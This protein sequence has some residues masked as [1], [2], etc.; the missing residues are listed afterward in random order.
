MSNRQKITLE[1]D[2]PEGWEFTGE[3]EAP[4]DRHWF[5]QETETVVWGKGSTSRY[6]RP[7]VKRKWEWPSWLKAYAISMDAV[8]DWYAWSDLPHI[9]EAFRL[10]DSEGKSSWLCENIFD[11]TPPTVTDWKESL[12]INPNRKDEEE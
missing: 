8:G 11:F 2:L 4:G 10:W 6:K 9:C 1:F 3:Y 12:I 5:H 7:I